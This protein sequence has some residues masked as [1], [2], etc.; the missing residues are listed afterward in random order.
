MPKVD[1]RKAAVV[2]TAAS[3]GG[4]MV[5][6]AKQIAPAQKRLSDRV[7]ELFDNEGKLVGYLLV[8]SPCVRDNGRK[9]LGIQK[10]I[11]TF[12]QPANSALACPPWPTCTIRGACLRGSG[13]AIGRRAHRAAPLSCRPCTA[14][15]GRAGAIVGRL[16]DDCWR[17]RAGRRRRCGAVLCPASLYDRARERAR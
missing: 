10:H 5:T 8:A 3:A 17:G 1:S 4:G 2:Q 16:L 14:L 13:K 12:G 15:A 7:V 9:L 11:E 6:F